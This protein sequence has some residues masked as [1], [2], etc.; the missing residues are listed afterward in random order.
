MSK[1]KKKKKKS[2]ER[3]NKRIER[4][5]Y[6]VFGNQGCSS[7][8][9]EHKPRVEAALVDQKVG[10]IRE[11]PIHQ[12]FDSSLGNRADFVEP[13]CEIIESFCLPKKKI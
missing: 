7:A 10:K 3:W 12:S 9:S 8:V 11:I 13:Y 4:L 5:A 2:R 6:L 1:K